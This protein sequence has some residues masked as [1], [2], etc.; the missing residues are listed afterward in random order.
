MFRLRVVAVRE[1]DLAIKGL[2]ED[3]SEIRPGLSNVLK[4]MSRVAPQ[5]GLNR[6]SNPVEA[7]LAQATTQ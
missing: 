7:M 6:F 3:H 2:K 1:V 5:F 4:L